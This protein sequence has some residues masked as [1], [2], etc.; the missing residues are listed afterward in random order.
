VPDQRFTTVLWRGKW[1]I[2]ASLAVAIGLAILITSRSAR[3]YESS[4]TI[5]VNSAN[6]IGQNGSSPADIQAGN[7]VLAQTYAT[8]IDDRSFLAQIRDRVM[9]GDLSTADLES[10]LSSS[11]VQNTALIKLAAEGPSPENAKRLAADVA[12]EFVKTVRGD[13]LKQ[14]ASLRTQIQGQITQ[15]DRSISKLPRGSD[16]ANSLR[17]ARSELVRQ[18]AGLIAGSIAQGNSVVLTA[19]P[20]GS[21]APVRPRPAL[22]LI[23]GILLGLLVGVVLAFL[24]D[25]LDRGL[26]SSEE[27]EELL[28]VPL[29]ASIPVR[30]RAPPGG[31]AG[32]VSSPPTA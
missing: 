26:H 32:T 16:R 7:Q 8:L 27:A 2:V 22:N 17:A 19:P 10:R 4:A 14:T 20:S 11:W 15:I 24:R 25:R 12:R 18:L 5:Q 21:S 1:L 3:V 31:R 23:A 6:S 30:K 9:G 29:L 13:A 28:G